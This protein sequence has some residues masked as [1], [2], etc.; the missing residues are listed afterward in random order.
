MRARILLLIGLSLLLAACELARTPAASLSTPTLLARTAGTPAV[1]S[2][3]QSSVVPPSAYRSTTTF[4]D[5]IAAPLPTRVRPTITPDLTCDFPRP[6]LDNPWIDADVQTFAP[7]GNLAEEQHFQNYTIRIYDEYSVCCC[8]SSLEVLKG[9]ERIYAA[10]ALAHLWIGRSVDEQFDDSQSIPAG[11]DVT[12]DGISDLVITH[13][14]GGAHCCTFYRVFELGQEF[15]LLGTIDAGD[16]YSRIEDLDGDSN[17]EVIVPDWAY[18]DYGPWPEAGKPGPYVVLHYTDGGYRLAQELMRKPALTSAELQ[19]LVAPYVQEVTQGHEP[20]YDGRF[21][22]DIVGLIYSG[23]PKQAEQFLALV[24]PNDPVR[25]QSFLHS[26]L[27][28]MQD[29]LY[30]PEIKGV[31]DEWPWPESFLVPDPHHHVVDVTSGIVPLEIAQGFAFTEVAL[32]PHVERYDVATSSD[33]D[34]RAFRVE[35]PAAAGGFMDRLIVEDLRSGKTYEIQGLPAPWRPFSD[36]VWIDPDI[37]VFDRWSQP[38]YGWHYAVDVHQGKLI[39]AAPFP[40]QLPPSDTPSP[41]P[42]TTLTPTASPLALQVSMPSAND[43]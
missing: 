36:L 37:L 40:D 5:D 25:Q 28:I 21:W 9:G 17:W 42:T 32:D 10:R 27:G 3:D 1:V 2:S 29:S 16:Y 7:V 24:W 8:G 39:L 18:E 38:H 41:S 30:W 6:N 34:Y 11:Q 22:E 33:G 12:G 35:E 43:S 15:R 4:P 20:S 19:T 23:N 13:S 31:S 26:L 14:T